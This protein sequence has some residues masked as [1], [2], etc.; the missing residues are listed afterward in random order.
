MSSTDHI[1]FS[2]Y[3]YL[4]LTRKKHES[5]RFNLLLLPLSFIG[6]DQGDYTSFIYI[7]QLGDMLQYQLISG[8]VSEH[9][10]VS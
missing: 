6:S 8:T 7:Y 9:A 10:S 1:I 4:Q 2:V 5:F 3:K